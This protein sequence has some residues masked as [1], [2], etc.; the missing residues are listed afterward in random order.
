MPRM[1]RSDPVTVADGWEGRVHAAQLRNLSMLGVA[2]LTDAAIPANRVIRIVGPLFDV[3]AA[4]I[5]CR[6]DGNRFALHASV[7]NGLFM[8]PTGVLVSVSA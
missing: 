2:V 5:A 3:V 1:S 6:A 7:L 8:R 4:V